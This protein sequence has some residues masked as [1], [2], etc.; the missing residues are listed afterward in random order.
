[1]RTLASKA[2]NAGNAIHCRVFLTPL[3]KA[4]TGIS[5]TLKI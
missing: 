2:G 5:H 1:V 3:V 4:A